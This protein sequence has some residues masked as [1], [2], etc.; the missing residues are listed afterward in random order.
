M[1]GNLSA[2]WESNGDPGRVSRGD[3]D[4]GGPSF[5][6]YQFAWNYGVPQAFCQ[7]LVDT[8]YEYGTYLLDNSY[9]VDVLKEAWRYV[10]Q[11]DFQNFYNKQHEYTKAQ[12]YDVAV[13]A[14][15]QAGFNAEK[16]SQVMQDVIWSRAVQYNHYIIE[17]FEEAC[18][19]KLGY[20][21]LSYID[22]ISFDAAMI[23]AIYEICS[24]PEWTNGSPSQRYG[25]Y[26][27]FSQEKYEALRKLEQEVG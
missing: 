27:R 8:G 21:N 25:L 18:L 4:L 12:Y 10:A 26:S 6:A 16:H 24:T 22:D 7:W 13:E 19:N 11:V 1:L 23:A 3:G 2:R 14:L 9:D 5:G 17:M 15:R 20:P